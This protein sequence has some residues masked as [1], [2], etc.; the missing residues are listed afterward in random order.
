MDATSRPQELTL[1]PSPSPDPNPNQVVAEASVVEGC[2]AAEGG[3]L[4]L[5]GCATMLNASQV[6]EPEP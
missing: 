6:R 3:G 2:V 5:L 4:H 1:N